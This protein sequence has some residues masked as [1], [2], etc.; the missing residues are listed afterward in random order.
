MRRLLFIATIFSFCL[1]QQTYDSEIQPI[2]DANCTRCHGSSGDL[3]LTQGVSYSNIVNVASKGYSGFM[4][5]KPGDHMNSVMHQKIVGNAAFGDRMPKNSTALSNSD[6][7][8]I[9][10]WIED[11]ALMDWSGNPNKPNLVGHWPFNE[12]SGSDV[13]DMTTN[14]NN[15]ISIGATWSTDTPG[16][17]NLGSDDYSLSFDGNDDYVKIITDP[18]LPLDNSPR[19][20]SA[21]IKDDN[22]PD[23]WGSIM[24]WGDGDCNGKMWG[25]GKTNGKLSIWGGCQDWETD[26]VIP[27][28][29]WVFIAMAYDGQNITAWLNDFKETQTLIGPFQTTSSD[30]FIGAE[31][32][33]N[34]LT[35]RNYFKGKIDEVSIWDNALNDD[36]IN[37]I[38][39]DKSNN[40]YTGPF[41]TKITVNVP[42]A[43]GYSGYLSLRVF[44]QGTMIKDELPFFSGAIHSYDSPNI[45]ENAPKDLDLM[46]DDWLQ[47]IP[48]GDYPIIAFYDE[49]GEHEFDPYYEHIGIGFLKV[50]NGDMAEAIISPLERLPGPVIENTGLANLTVN[51]NEDFTLSVNVN[52]NISPLAGEV[53]RVYITYESGDRSIYDAEW[54]N[55]ISDGLYECYISSN[56]ITNKGIV[57]WLDAMDE[58][59]ASSFMGPYDIMVQFESIF[60]SS[61]PT[62]EYVMISVPAKVNN[63]STQGVFVEQLGDPDPSMWRTFKWQNGAYQ[64][65]A[66]SLSPGSAVWLISKDIGEIY[67]GNGHSTQLAKEFQIN[68]SDGW[69]QIGSPYNFPIDIND[70]FSVLVSSEVE[71][72]LYQYTGNDNYMQTSVMN[73]GKGYWVYSNGNGQIKINTIFGFPFF[74]D[75]NDKILEKQNLGWIV[76]LEVSTGDQRDQSTRFGVHPNASAAYD[77]YDFHEPPVIGE[78][79]SAYFKHSEVGNLNQDIQNEGEAFYSWSLAVKTN[80]AGILELVIPGINNIPNEHSVK[81]F[82]PVTQIVHDMRENLSFKFASQGSENPHYFELMVGKDELISDKLEKEGI[83][84]NQFELAQNVPNPFNPV[85]NIRISLKEDATISLKVFNLLGEEINS[86]AMNKPMSKGNHRFIW[87]GKSD[88]GQQL[89]SG[90]YLYRLE[91]IT[92]NGSPVYQNTK[93]MILMK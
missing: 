24:H 16:V 63:M 36:E 83:V 35:F 86:L 30:F 54:C 27:Q 48:Y 42:N 89:P 51:E 40:N 77:K 22:S 67:A 79:I 39:L 50:R 31:T 55:E 17:G 84:P 15:G 82:D 7:N 72:E 2:W 56:D 34:G 49:Y 74:E 28:N 9:K 75:S 80:Q 3:D 92:N 32:V 46:I 88:N 26:L 23:G 57:I 8:K 21:W 76:N 4:L 70:D 37:K 11:G 69:N 64:E 66:G 41:K 33:D 6:E 60:V 68:L 44:D 20:V 85:T 14:L 53:D 81:L 71:Q 87:S 78:Y 52:K 91:V 62:E 59:G 43:S 10:K 29:E 90:I 38:Y 13:Y 25:F 45:Y 19:T 61:F 5:V 58:Y 1:A 93:K 18:D 47:N 73:P 65:N 12:G